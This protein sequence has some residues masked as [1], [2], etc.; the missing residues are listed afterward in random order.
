MLKISYRK[1]GAYTSESHR[2]FYTMA[3][4]VVSGHEIDLDRTLPWSNK[5]GP[6]EDMSGRCAKTIEVVTAMEIC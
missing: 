6:L 3:W 5:A 1:V 2:S 4:P